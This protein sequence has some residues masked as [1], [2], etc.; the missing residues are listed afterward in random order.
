MSRALHVFAKELSLIYDY[1]VREFV[2]GIFDAL[3]P[4][5]FWHIPA[6]QRG[7]H[8][9]ICR[10]IGGLVQHVKL[11][12]DF[13]EC[14][15]DMWEPATSTLVDQLDEDDHDCV[16]AGVLLH[17]LFKRG[18]TEDCSHSFTNKQHACVAHGRFT[19][20][21]IRY[22]LRGEDRLRAMCPQHLRDRI[23]VAVEL[24]MGRWTE[25]LSPTDKTM[26]A[27]NRVVSTVHLADYTASRQIHAFL[28][29]R[30]TDESN[31]E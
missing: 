13:A 2:Q 3:A 26:L 24:H 9:P 11:A 29:E 12:V 30:Y 27:S 17:D 28:G 6:S 15:T 4:D 25:N 7:H 23:I 22:Y 1:R 14:F 18:E 10:T 19:A 5:Y 8:P 16:I 20:T 31:R 21:E